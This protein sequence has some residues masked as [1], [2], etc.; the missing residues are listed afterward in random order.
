MTLHHNLFENL[1]QRA[2]RVRFGKVHVYNNY[3]KIDN[4]DNYV[5]SWGVGIESAIY[6][7]NNFFWVNP[8][9]GITPDRFIGV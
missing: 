9:S 5:Y 2:A 6:A 3:Y 8:G 7:E 1:G 4:P